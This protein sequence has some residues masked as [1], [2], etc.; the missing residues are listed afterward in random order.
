MGNDEELEAS[1]PVNDGN[2]DN[3]SEGN[4]S[5]SAEVKEVENGAAE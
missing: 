2:V 1:A 5:N 4:D 3:D